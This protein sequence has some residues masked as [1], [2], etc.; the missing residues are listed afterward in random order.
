MKYFKTLPTQKYFYK[1]FFQ[2]E[3]N[4]GIC[5]SEC[6]TYIRN[7]VEVIG[8]VDKQTYYLGTT[9]CEKT[10]KGLKD[11]DLDDKVMQRIKYFKPKYKK[12]DQIR[13]E[14]DELTKREDIIKIVAEYYIDYTGQVTFGFM[15]FSNS[16]RWF[17]TVSVDTVGMIPAIHKEFAKEL[18]TID[19][20][21]PAHKGCRT[22]KE[23]ISAG[24]EP[25][26]FGEWI[27]KNL[28]EGW[29]N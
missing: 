25:T 29:G 1:N 5:C 16:G 10:S 24:R 11:I 19:F 12:L 6:G 27:A 13:K 28:P 18:E 8:G 7:V 26:S 9:C 21:N 17:R 20:Y 2:C 14:Y 3:K 4:E 23:I 15:Y 22:T